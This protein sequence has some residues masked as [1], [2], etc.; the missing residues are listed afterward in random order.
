MPT[1][2]ETLVSDHELL[3]EL[4]PEELA[5]FILEYLNTLPEGHGE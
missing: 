2:F 1:I 4:E 5:G 3:L